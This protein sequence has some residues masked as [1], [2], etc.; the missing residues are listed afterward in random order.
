MASTEGASHGSHS[1]Y[2]IP[3]HF[4]ELIINDES[5]SQASRDSARMTLEYSHRIRQERATLPANN[6]THAATNEESHAPRSFIPPHLLENI[7]NDETQDPTV[8]SGAES[9]LQH[10]AA[11]REARQ[12]VASATATE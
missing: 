9:T 10:S 4:L 6:N 8:R 2:F 3:P 12:S 1:C 11:V 7:A 5:A